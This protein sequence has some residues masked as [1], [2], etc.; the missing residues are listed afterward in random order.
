MVLEIK[1]APPKRGMVNDMKKPKTKYTLR[2]DGRIVRT[3]IIDGKRKYFYG[4]SDEEVDAKYATAINEANKPLLMKNLIEQWWVK[5]EPEISPNTVSGFKTAKNRIADEFG[6]T[7]VTDLTAQMILAWLD[8]FKRKQYSQKVI[9]NAKSV[10]KQIMDQALI[11]GEIPFN[12]CVGL[13]VVKGKPK[14]PRQPATDE[15]LKRIEESKT[16]SNIGRMFYLMV[17]TGLRRGECVA[18]QHKH[19]DRKNMT[20]TVEQSCAYDNSG[21]PVIKTPKTEAGRRTVHVP[22][23][24]LE[25][26]PEGKPDDYVF[27]KELPKKTA[28]SKAITQFRERTGISGTPHQLRHKYASI[29]HSA[30]VDVKDA[31]Y[32]LGHSDITMTQN[33]YTHLEERHKDVVGNQIDSYLLSE[34][35]SESQK[36]E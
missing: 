12:P 4:H 18:L 30:K 23:F 16:E 33:I 20:I 17:Y 10:L 19:I 11:A 9:S 27:F 1:K 24:V 29:L 31:Q 36:S 26:I 3:E 22:A 14:E 13:P 35:L 28:S 8:S 21:R 6:D 32:L 34:K 2:A 15:D 7:P 25:A 5:K